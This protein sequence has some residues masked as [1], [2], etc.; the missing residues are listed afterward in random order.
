MNLQRDMQG[1]VMVLRPDGPVTEPD[2]ERF[3]REVLE[4]FD[5][6]L[7][8]MAVDT[9]QVSFV[10]SRG[11]EALLD[12]AERMVESGKSL[13]LCGVNDTLRQVFELTE[14]ATMFEYYEDAN[15]AAR[16]FL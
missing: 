2:A 4:A 1:A 14:L 6:T 16:S 10:D 5:E 15:A 13:K 8:R 9:S 3:C 7:G 11:L 12:V